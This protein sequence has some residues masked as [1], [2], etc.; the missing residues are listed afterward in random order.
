VTSNWKSDGLPQKSCH[1]AGKT[2]LPDFSPVITS[3]NFNCNYQNRVSVR[4]R[5][6]EMNA[7]SRSAGWSNHGRLPR[8]VNRIKSTT[9]G[10]GRSRRLARYR[11]SV[12]VGAK[13][14][15]IWS[16]SLSDEADLDNLFDI[17]SQNTAMTLRSLT[18]LFCANVM[19]GRSCPCS[20]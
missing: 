18:A 14:M 7:Q 15:R 3:C 11:A 6:W 2:S 12:G 8:D 19:A 4:S 10:G 9:F 1:P 16:A 17:S 5:H 20:D 13:K